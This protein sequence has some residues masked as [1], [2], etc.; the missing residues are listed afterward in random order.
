MTNYSEYAVYTMTYLRIVCY[1]QVIHKVWQIIKQPAT[2]TYLNMTT[3]PLISL[4]SFLLVTKALI[5][6]TLKCIIVTLVCHYYLVL[7]V[8]YICN[9]L[10][11]KD[12]L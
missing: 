11:H 12:T 9:N 2:R 4:M 10:Q 6:S 8:Q 1:L 5:T 3:R 7:Q